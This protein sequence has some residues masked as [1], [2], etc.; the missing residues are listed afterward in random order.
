MDLEPGSVPK[1]AIRKQTNIVKES[2]II[3]LNMKFYEAFMRFP[4]VWSVPKVAIRKQ[5]QITKVAIRKQTRIKAKSLVF[6]SLKPC[7]VPFEKNRR[8]QEN[9]RKYSE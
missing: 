6:T 8:I 3:C 9:A 7:C 4:E 5:T 1:V 2:P